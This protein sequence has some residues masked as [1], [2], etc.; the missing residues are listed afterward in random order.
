MTS[1]GGF[2]FRNDLLP[3]TLSGE[4]E[5]KGDERHVSMLHGKSNI[6]YPRSS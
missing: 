4:N 6:I 1:F 5:E 3:L 2:E